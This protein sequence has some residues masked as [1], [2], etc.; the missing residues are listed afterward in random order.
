[1]ESKARSSWIIHGT[2]GTQDTRRMNVHEA[3]VKFGKAGAGAGAN[4]WLISRG[5]DDTNAAGHVDT[6]ISG[7]FAADLLVSSQRN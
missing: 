5:F 1:M 4:R 3:V 7:Q 6:E 2:D